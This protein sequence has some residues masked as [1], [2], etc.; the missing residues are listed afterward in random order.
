MIFGVLSNFGVLSRHERLGVPLKRSTLDDSPVV[1][2]LLSPGHINGPHKDYFPFLEVALSL[3]QPT[4]PSIF[5]PQRS[6]KPRLESSPVGSSLGASNS[7][8]IPPFSAG[9]TPPTNYITGRRSLERVESN[10]QG[11]SASPEQLR[12]AH[13]SNSNLATAF[14]SFSKPFSFDTSASSSPPTTI[15]RKRFS[16]NGSYMAVPDANFLH[17]GMSGL[18]RTLN[19]IDEPKF[20]YKSQRLNKPHPLDVAKE[21]KFKI[22]LKNQNTFHNEGYAKASLLDKVVQRQYLA[23]SDAYAYMLM[24]WEMPMMKIKLLK[25]STIPTHS[26]SAS[27]RLRDQQSTSL[28]SIGRKHLGGEKHVGFAATLD[29]RRR[30]TRCGKVKTHDPLTGVFRCGTCAWRQVPLLCV[31]CNER[32][33]GYVNPCLICSHVVHSKCRSYLSVDTTDAEPITAAGNTCISGC[34]CP[35]S[36]FDLPM[37][38]LPEHPPQKSSPSTIKEN[39]QEEQGWRNEDTW[40]DVAYESLAKNLGAAGAR[41]VRPKSSRI[42]RGLERKQSSRA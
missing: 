36:E 38:E 29:V 19:A 7:D 11:L 28:I 13:R 22:T 17:G 1:E 27:K 39:D 42:W 41:Y 12:N 2:G 24:M 40:E 18:S 9:V 3:K 20:A 35:C 5:V 23:Y 37:V 4:T 15:P 16:P 8:S 34:G 25:Q 21:P 33:R 6:G 30:C 14:A 10:G 31:F 26:R 32:I